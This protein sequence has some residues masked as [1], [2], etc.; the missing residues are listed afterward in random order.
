MSKTPSEWVIPFPFLL[1]PDFTD[2]IGYPAILGA[3]GIPKLRAAYKLAPLEPRRFIALH[4]MSAGDE[5]AFD[6]G[7]VSGAGQLNHWIYLQFMHR[8]HVSAWLAMH[9]I[10]LGSSEEMEKH[11]LILDRETNEAFVTT[12]EI[13]RRIVQAQ[14]FDRPINDVPQE[15]P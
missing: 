9:N 6:D 10:D 15:A 14:N 4:W 1:P 11:W 2:Q 5:L 13:G 12:R 8:F 7:Q 3:H